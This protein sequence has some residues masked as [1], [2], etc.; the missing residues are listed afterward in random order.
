MA[1]RQGL[2]ALLVVAFVG[3][4]AI[5]VD[6]TQHG[7]LERHDARVGLWVVAH[8]PHALERVANVMTK[9]GGAWSLVTL[10]ALGA[11]L[12]LHRGRRLD[13]TF[14]VGGL[15]LVSLV[16][17]GLKIAFRRPRPAIGYLTPVSHTA[18]FP[19]GHTSGS[20]VVFVLLAV[21]L[22]TRHRNAVI[23]GA[24]LLAATVGVT[25]VVVEAHWTTDVLAGYC[26][27]A[28]V[29]AAVLIVLDGL[30]L[31]PSVG[32][33]GERKARQGGHEER[34]STDRPFAE[35]RAHDLVPVGDLA[36]PQRR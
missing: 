17:N 26:L 23:A 9:L 27:G 32:P 6:V 14:L 4:V 22:A 30:R 20:L 25:R 34:E 8:T 15:A 28:A 12:L 13:A 1:R 29:V 31:V 24:V 33:E 18:S 3:F 35:H 5:A 10:T 16:T 21:L 2:I 19:S 36:E 11:G 7:V